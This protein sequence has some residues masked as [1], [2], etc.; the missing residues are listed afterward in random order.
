MDGIWNDLRYAARTYLRSTGFTILAVTTLTIGI[1]AATAV[2]A[3]LNAV[4]L[5]PLPY[6][7]AERLVALVNTRRGMI[8]A[9]SHAAMRFE[10]HWIASQPPVEGI[11]VKPVVS[12]MPLAISSIIAPTAPASGADAGICSASSGAR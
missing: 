11:A 7:D 8:T 2:F 5:K 9:L 12:R 10:S 4:S 6:P 1:G 3:L